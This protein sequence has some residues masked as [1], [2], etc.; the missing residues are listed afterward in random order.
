[1]HIRHNKT[2]ISKAGFS[3]GWTRIKARRRCSIGSLMLLSGPI[4]DALK[5]SGSRILESP[6]SESLQSPYQSE[7]DR[8]API[9]SVKLATYIGTILPGRQ[10]NARQKK[11]KSHHIVRLHV[12]KLLP[13]VSTWSISR[14]SHHPSLHRPFLLQ[15]DV[16]ILLPI[17]HRVSISQA[18]RSD[19]SPTN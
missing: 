12:P 1:M 17:Y 18:F 15:I 9:V 16:S 14:L 13:P 6:F 2:T 19:K 11:N 7:I 10:C 4:A 8:M 3:S 5:L